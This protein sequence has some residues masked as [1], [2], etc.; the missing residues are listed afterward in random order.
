MSAYF[1][2]LLISKYDVIKLWIL[3]TFPLP[4][5]SELSLPVHYSDVENFPLNFVGLYMGDIFLEAMKAKDF[6]F[7][8]I[9][10]QRLKK[11]F[12]HFNSSEGQ[13]KIPLKL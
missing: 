4:I 11:Q 3:E 6:F 8:F 10:V 7:L 12:T 2:S 9:H 13:N 5:L 1:F